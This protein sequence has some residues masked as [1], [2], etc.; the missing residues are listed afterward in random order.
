MRLGQAPYEFLN[1]NGEPAGINI[2]VM[3]AVMAEIGI[4]VKFV[5]K[6]WSIALRTFERG[7]ADIILVNSRRYKRSHT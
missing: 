5:M 4:P 2:D 6:E 7:N 1:S 3:R